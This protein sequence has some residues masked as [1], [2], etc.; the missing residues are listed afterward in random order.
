MLFLD[1]LEVILVIRIEAQDLHDPTALFESGFRFSGSFDW[2]F[3]HGKFE[4][5]NAW[6]LPWQ[7][8]VVVLYV[9][10]CNAST[11]VLPWQNTLPCPALPC[12]VCC[13]SRNME[14]FTGSC[15]ACVVH[16]TLVW[17]TCLRVL[18]AHVGWL[19]RQVGDEPRKLPCLSPNLLRVR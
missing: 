4:D 10:I 19:C 2:A 12:P 17:S 11:N 13:S 16:G 7:N 14:L 8:E 15:S 9:C 6:V 1:L 18:Q 5:R 3:C